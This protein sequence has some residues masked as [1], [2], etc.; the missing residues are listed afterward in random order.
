MKWK[1]F[2]TVILLVLSIVIAAVGKWSFLGMLS[3][4]WPSMMVVMMLF[5]FVLGHGIA[6]RFSG[7][8]IDERNKMSLSRLQLV[9][10]TV[11]ILSAYLAAAI[12]N[13]SLGDS[14][15][16]LNIGVQKELW[17]LLGISTTSL[18]GSPLILNAKKN[19]PVDPIEADKTKNSLAR[20]KQIL[21]AQIDISTKVVSL[22]EEKA[23]FADIFQGDFTSN[24]AV[25]DLG[26]VQMFFFTIVLIVAYSYAVIESFS[27]SS[28]VTDLPTLDPGMLALLA[29]SHTGYLGVKAAHV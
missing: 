17:W 13:L 8:L 24:A 23:S 27:Q 16:P 28:A 19:N 21:P 25:I 14:E 6:G 4:L 9:L 29:I 5:L 18:V 20:Q 12:W 3:I 7:V 1:W 22:P 2:H 11:V 10:W 26:K 15:N